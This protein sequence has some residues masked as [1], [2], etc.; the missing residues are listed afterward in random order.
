ML[1]KVAVELFNEDSKVVNVAVLHEI[2]KLYVDIYSTNKYPYLNEM[3]RVSLFTELE[4]KLA[5]V[6]EE[7]QASIKKVN[8]YRSQDENQD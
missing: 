1:K 6:I 7:H 4:S 2:E 8:N 5:V 3:D